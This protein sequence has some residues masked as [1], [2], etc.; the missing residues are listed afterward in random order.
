MADSDLAEQ[1]R[2]QVELLLRKGRSDR[3]IYY[4]LTRLY[5]PNVCLAAVT[6]DGSIAGDG[7]GLTLP[8][9]LWAASLPLAAGAFHLVRRVRR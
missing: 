6:R 1:M 7:K 9:L 3:E 4:E 5:G 8:K 2:G